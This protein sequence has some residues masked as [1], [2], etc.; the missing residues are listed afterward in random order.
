MLGVKGHPLPVGTLWDF[1]RSVTP[2]DMGPWCQGLGWI[3]DVLRARGVRLAG[4]RPG[5][6]EL[7]SGPNCPATQL[8]RFQG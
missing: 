7:T 6:R 1:P 5:I 2:L 8:E 3:A 4:Q